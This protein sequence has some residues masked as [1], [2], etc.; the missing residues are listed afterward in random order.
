MVFFLKGQIQSLSPVPSP[1]IH[2]S[3]IPL[4]GPI[5]P[6]FYKVFLHVKTLKEAPQICRDKWA[7]P[8]QRVYIFFWWGGERAAFSIFLWTKAK[9]KTIWLKIPPSWGGFPRKNALKL[10]PQNHT[11]FLTKG[12]NKKKK[13]FEGL[14]KEMWK[15]NRKSLK[16]WQKTPSNKSVLPTPFKK[17]C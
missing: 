17:F 7:G 10:R 16:L 13:I 2:P 11:H 5:K 9:K 1:E 4:G 8:Q 3:P 12:K 6:L 14:L 15:K